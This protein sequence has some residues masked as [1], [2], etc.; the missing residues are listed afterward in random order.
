[1]LLMGKTD[2]AFAL[3]QLCK[4]I[5]NLTDM[6]KIII[7]EAGD[8]FSSQVGMCRNSAYKDP[9][10]CRNSAYKDPMMC[11]NSGYK[12]SIIDLNKKTA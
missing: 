5:K 4:I 12:D 7:I 2:R 10:M 8:T 9:M 11:R 1:M 6:N 3:N